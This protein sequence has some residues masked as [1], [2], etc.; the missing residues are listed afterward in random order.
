MKFSKN[1]SSI[2]YLQEKTAS[3][4]GYMLRPIPE[5]WLWPRGLGLVLD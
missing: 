3:L 1:Q 2:R 5:V 4:S